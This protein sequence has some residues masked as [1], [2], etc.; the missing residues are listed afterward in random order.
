MKQVYREAYVDGS[1]RLVII[2]YT[3]QL[4]RSVLFYSVMFMGG[5]ALTGIL[6]LVV[7]LWNGDK[8]LP[9]GIVIPF[10][11]PETTDGYE[12]NYLYQVSY[13]FWAPPGLTASQNF[14]FALAFNICIQYDVLVLKVRNLDEMIAKNGDGELNGKIRE[15]LTNIIQ[16]QQ[17]L[18]NFI[19]DLEQLYAFQTLVEVACNAIQ[20]IITLFVL[21]IDMW[22]PGYLVIIVSTFQLLL[23]CMLGTLIDVKSD[24]FTDQIYNISWHNMAKEDK[25]IFKFMLEMSQ[26]SQK[27]SCGRIMTVNMNM[28]VAIYKKIYTIFMMLQNV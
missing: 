6:P 22:F 5:V 24:V 17:R 9:F 7:Y 26:Q 28:F 27:L 12:L 1:E 16:Y 13:M 21:H 10:I 15:G 25:K 4:K 23:W 18:V 3:R 11:N 20:I 19:S 14:Y 2:K 8:I